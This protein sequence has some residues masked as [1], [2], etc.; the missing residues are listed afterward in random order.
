MKKK[1]TFTEI[2]I[3]YV[4]VFWFEIEKDNEL[5]TGTVYIRE[6][7]FITIQ[8]N[9]TEFYN[10]LTLTFKMKSFVVG[11]ERNISTNFFYQFLLQ[12]LE[13]KL[14]DKQTSLHLSMG[15]VINQYTKNDLDY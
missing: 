9:F 11:P 2:E 6:P 14:L 15:E 10:L 13:L 7:D 4:I 8:E 12:N 3:Q 1:E 5:S